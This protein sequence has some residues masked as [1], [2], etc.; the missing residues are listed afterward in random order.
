MLYVPTLVA[1]GPS[2][3]CVDLIENELADMAESVTDEVKD[4]ARFPNLTSAMVRTPPHQSPP[5]HPP[6]L[7]DLTDCQP[8]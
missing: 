2:L 8:R 6:F 4:L 1:Q 7:T 5:P 3:Q